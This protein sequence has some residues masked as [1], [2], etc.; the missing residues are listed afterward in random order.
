MAGF[1]HKNKSWSKDLDMK[2]KTEI[3]KG[4]NMKQLEII[5]NVSSRTIN[6]RIKDIGFEG[7]K[8]A[9]KAMCN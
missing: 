3:A 5:F 8:D 4:K 7:L 1:G 2:L 9:R 6:D